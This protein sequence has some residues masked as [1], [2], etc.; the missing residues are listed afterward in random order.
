MVTRSGFHHLH[1]RKRKA[2][3]P[4]P[5]RWKN[6]IDKLIYIAALAGPIMTIPQVWKIFIEKTAAGV[7]LI[8]WAAF[9]VVAVCWLIYGFAHQDKPI[10]V[11]NILWIIFETM[12]VIG[13]IIY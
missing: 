3:Y 13:V 12:I 11:S 10:I 5:V 1:A 4:H 8:S 7:S 2:P 9:L 6:F